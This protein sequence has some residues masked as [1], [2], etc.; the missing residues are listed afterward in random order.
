[1][2]VMVAPG[3]G[4][5]MMISNVTVPISPLEGIGPPV[6][7]APVMVAAGD[8]LANVIATTAAAILTVPWMLIS[9]CLDRPMPATAEG[10]NRQRDQI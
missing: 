6:V 9:L 4:A 5:L 1:M 10:I 2:P 8:R 3:A 7:L